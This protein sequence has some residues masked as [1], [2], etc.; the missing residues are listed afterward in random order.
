MNASL[1]FDVRQIYTEA[2][3]MADATLHLASLKC[4]IGRMIMAD[5]QSKQESRGIK[6]CLCV[7]EL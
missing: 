4:M 3:P 1:D 6:P 2:R 7:D 5:M